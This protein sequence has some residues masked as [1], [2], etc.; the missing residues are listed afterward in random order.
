MIESGIIA[1]SGADVQ[2]TA[3]NL[4]TVPV[5]IER[6]RIDQ[7]TCTNYGSNSANLT[8]WIMQSG[9]TENSQILAIPLTTLIPNET[10]TL[11]E[12]LGRAVE[13]SGNIRAKSS[14]ASTL[15]LSITGTNIT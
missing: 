11:F 7:A 4:F 13:K 2:T 3:K 12:L 1:L 9:E 6:F 10:L 8:V 14:V 15:S 5:N